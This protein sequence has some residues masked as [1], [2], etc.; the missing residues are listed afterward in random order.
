[1]ILGLSSRPAEIADAVRPLVRPWRSR[2]E[3][4]VELAAVAF[5]QLEEARMLRAQSAAGEMPEWV[6]GNAER[7]ERRA[8]EMADGLLVDFDEV[9][10]L[11]LE[12]GP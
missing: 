12:D 3:L 11:V 6:D 2:Y 7:W 1:M 5:W 10:R 9:A 8:R 4:A